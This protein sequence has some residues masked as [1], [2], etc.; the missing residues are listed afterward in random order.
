MARLKLKSLITSFTPQGDYFAIISPNGLVKVISLS[1]SL[2]LSIYIYTHIRRVFRKLY[3]GEFMKTQENIY[4][5]NTSNGSLLAEWSQSDADSDD[6]FSCMA[7]SFVGK[8]RS[9]ERGTC[10]L[11]L[12][13]DAGEILTVNVFSGEKKWKSTCHAGKERGTCL[14]AL[15]ADAGEILT[16]NVFSGEKKWKST[17]HAGGIAGLSFTNRGR[18]LYTVGNDGVATEMNSETGEVVRQFKV[19]KTHISSSAFCDEKI[20]AIA[21]GKIR[22]FNWENEK[23]LE[24]TF[25]IVHITQGLVQHISISD[26]AKTIVTSGP[27]EKHLQ[28][29][30]CDLSTGVISKGPILSMRHPP[31]AFECKN[32]TN[33][34]DVLVVL[35]VSESGVA[36]VWNLKSISEE[37]ISPVKVTVKASKGEMDLQNSGKKSRFSI[38][39]ARLHAVENDGRVTALIA[40]GSTDSPQFSFLDIS[41]PVEDIV[42]T[43]GDETKK[44]SSE[45]IQENG[46][47]AGIGPHEDDLEAVAVPIQKKKSNKKRAASDPDLADTENSIDNALELLGGTV[48]GNDLEIPVEELFIKDLLIILHCALELLGG[49]V[50]GNDLEIPVEELFI[51]D[52]LI[53][54]HCG[55]ITNRKLLEIILTNKL[56]LLLDTAHEEP[57]DGSQIDKGLNEPTMGEKLA[58]L[59]LLENNEVKSIEKK[60]ISQH[61]MPPSAD[62]VH[63][64]LKQALHADDRALILKCLHTQDDKVIANSVSLLNPSDVIKLLDSLISIIRSRGAG[65]ACAL[66]WLRSLLLQHASGIMSQ[67]SSISA[68]NSLY[69][70]IESRVSTFHPALRLSSCVD[71]LYTATV[72]DGFDE[73]ATTE[74]IVYEDSDESED[75][76]SEDAMETD[77]EGGNVEP[78]QDFSDING[79]DD[80]AFD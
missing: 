64:L 75:K 47:V 7:C 53:I 54:L 14:L 80:L 1:P 52:L 49:T 70:L 37:E 39:A 66:P 6:S 3:W 61:V 71:L 45:T 77:E 48:F 41:N 12:G 13:A 33:G 26:V 51:K 76:E 22:I 17:C 35:S 43:A 9:K 25:F 55:A 2:S 19:S 10:L 46:V 30:K 68:L 8:K 5:W 20:L 29:W 73:N 16:V 23:E 67:E 69:Q 62:S 65:V 74:P 11:A 38:M 44:T 31:I 27:G 72:E 4:I 58:S 42:I 15:G 79:C 28:V 32:S 36:H 34:E 40:Y 50:F 60:E 21:S 56:A 24:L 57:M 59:N 18:I 63:V 78:L